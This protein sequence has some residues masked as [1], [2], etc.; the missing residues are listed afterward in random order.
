MIPTIESSIP[1]RFIGGLESTLRRHGYALVTA[2]TGFDQ[3]VEAQHG[4]D[5]IGLGAEA[6]VVLGLEHDEALLR[7][8]QSRGVPIVCTGVFEPDFPLPTIGFD[9]RSLGATAMTSTGHRT[10]NPHLPL[11]TCRPLPCFG[12]FS[13]APDARE[14]QP[15]TVALEDFAPIFGRTPI[16][17]SDGATPNARARMR[18]DMLGRSPNA[19]TNEA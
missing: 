2:I 4:R 9:N 15:S 12:P 19:G 14:V 3:A 6:L 5:L 16:Q 10:S 18:C 11:C 7:A 13:I 1:A 17:G 8:A